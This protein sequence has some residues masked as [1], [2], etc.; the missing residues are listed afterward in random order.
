MLYQS[1]TQNG[2]K[3]NINVGK[4]NIFKREKIFNFRFL[5]FFCLSSKHISPFFLRNRRYG[6]LFRVFIEPVK[7]WVLSLIF[8]V[9]KLFSCLAFIDF[10]EKEN[11]DSLKRKFWQFGKENFDSLK[12]KFWQFGKENFDS[13]KRKFWQFGKENFD[14]LEKENFDSLEK[15]ILLEVHVSQKVTKYFKILINN[16]KELGINIIIFYQLQIS[17]DVYHFVQMRRNSVFQRNK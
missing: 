6:K 4:L 11:F 12:R 3:K 8:R 17:S 5:L 9:I 15:E 7:I 1:W 16:H 2:Y 14:S 10:F 13:L